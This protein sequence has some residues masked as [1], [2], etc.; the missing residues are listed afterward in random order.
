LSR[1]VNANTRTEFMTKSFSNRTTNDKRSNDR[2]HPKVT[3]TQNE[4]TRMSDN[5]EIQDIVEEFKQLQLQQTVLVDRLQ[6]LDR[7]RDNER[8]T[9]APSGFDRSWYSHKQRRP[10]ADGEFH[11][12]DRVRIKNPGRFQTS[13]GNITKIGP[14]RI[15][16]QGDDGKNPIVRAAKNLTLEVPE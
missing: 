11:I 2:N 1:S 9:R 8:A 3:S 5:R 16:I 12:G 6:Q 13:I 15:T 7:N 14:S 10:R 4:P